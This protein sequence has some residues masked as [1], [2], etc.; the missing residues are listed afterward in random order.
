METFLQSLVDIVAGLFGG[1][2]ARPKPPQN[3]P[4]GLPPGPTSP[5]VTD[6]TEP[7]DSS[8][9]RPEDHVLITHE[10]EAPRIT[11]GPEFDPV[12]AP[13][14]ARDTD[15]P[16]EQ[17]GP[18]PSPVPNSPEYRSRYLWCIDNGH[19]ALS[20]GKRSPV[21]EDGRQLFEWEFNRDVTSRIMAKLEQVGA[22]YFEVTPEVQI[23]NFLQERVRRANELSSALPKLFVSVH[24]NAGPAPDMQSFTGDNV[25]GIETWHYYGSTTGRKMAAVFQRHLINQ[26]G[27]RNRH[28]RSKVSGQFYVLRATRMP[29]ILTENGFYNNR[30]EL[31]LML[32]PAFRQQVADAHVA[33]ILE[34]DRD[35]L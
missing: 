1:D 35:G 33:A 32:T 25:R 20:P 6:P 2:P 4:P 10:N 12:P 9:L 34:I 3:L 23:G 28:L 8:E 16:P 21:L 11:D 13:P 17:P 7:Q 18:T 24:G 15:G 27:L 14:P 5:R 26:T 22:A 31:P 29:A 19:G 30:F